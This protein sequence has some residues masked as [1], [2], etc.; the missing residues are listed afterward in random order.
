MILK[1]FKVKDMIIELREVFRSRDEAVIPCS[2]VC[3]ALNALIYRVNLLIDEKQNTELFEKLKLSEEERLDSAFKILNDHN[4]RLKYL[5]NM[6]NLRAM[7]E[8]I[9]D[10][11]TI[12]EKK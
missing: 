5:E 2:S 7:K 12:K 3:D 6:H 4:N 10:F 1:L 11:K 9:N 8:Q